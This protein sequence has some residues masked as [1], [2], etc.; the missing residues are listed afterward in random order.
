MEEDSTPYLFEKSAQLDSFDPHPIHHR[1]V[2]PLHQHR[3]PE[4]RTPTGR[5]DLPPGKYH[6]V[7]DGAADSP[8]SSLD[9]EFEGAPLIVD[10]RSRPFLTFDIFFRKVIFLSRTGTWNSGEKFNLYFRIIGAE[11]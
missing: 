4:K 1:Q 7:H 9:V 10:D 11:K 2:F 3:E 5:D 8:H 6:E